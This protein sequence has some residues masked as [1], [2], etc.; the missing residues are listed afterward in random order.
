[1]AQEVTTTTPVTIKPNTPIVKNGKFLMS[2][3]V[4]THYAPSQ[5]TQHSSPGLLHP[6]D[7]RVSRMGGGRSKRNK[8]RAT[9]SKK[10]HNKNSTKR[11]K[12]RR[13]SRRK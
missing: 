7:P 3:P 9:C 1:M 10:R 11:S 8:R 6:N 5:Y 2:S 4:T 13:Y 12:K